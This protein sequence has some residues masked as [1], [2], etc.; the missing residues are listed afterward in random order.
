ML[1]DRIVCGISDN[2]IQRRLLAE[3]GLTYKK[4]L[5]ISQ[6]IEAANRNMCELHRPSAN[7]SKQRDMASVN[8]EI[9]KV[10]PNPTGKSE[11]CYHC[12]KTGHNPAACLF[13][14]AMCRFCD[15]VGHLKAVCYSRK[16]AEAHRNKTDPQARPVLT[17]SQTDT[18][19]QEDTDEYTLYTL[20]SPSSTL[21]ITVAVQMEGSSVQMELD[22]GAAFSLMS[23]T[24]FRQ[25]FPT[26]ELQPSTIR[27]CAYSGE[28]IEV[29]GSVYIDVIYKE[30]SAHVQLPLLIVRH[31]GPTL[32]G[33][34]WLQQ[35]RLDWREIHTIQ[36]DPLEALL[37]K[38]NAVFNSTLGTL[39]DF[40]AHI[41]VDQAAKP[42]YCKARSIPYSV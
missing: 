34:N 5:E 1:R 24:A 38:Y 25:L 13:K 7:S 33:R 23:E 4:A 9:N 32:M 21:P 16:K 37:E 41:H 22:T 29:M 15:K 14:D 31:N 8:N 3:L 10:A 27:L 42:K 6:G 11:T 26:K 28:P 35:L 12:R 36:L 19:Q 40:Q 18:A 2:T 30:Q 39:R 17:V 20:H